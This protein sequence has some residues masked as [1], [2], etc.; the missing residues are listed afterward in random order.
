[1]Q[2]NYVLS[3][4]KK[5]AHHCGIQFWYHKPPCAA[6]LLCLEGVKSFLLLYVYVARVQARAWL[7][8][9]WLIAMETWMSCIY[10][11][12]SWNFKSFCIHTCCSK[13]PQHIVNTNVQWKR[14]DSTLLAVCFKLPGWDSSDSAHFSWIRVFPLCH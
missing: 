8:C 13:K 1:M 9:E 6:W 7:T 2:I 5:L 4:T 12:A 10:Y 3:W 14:V 11:L